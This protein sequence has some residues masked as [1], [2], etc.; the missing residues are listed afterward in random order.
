MPKKKKVGIIA[1]GASKINEVKAAVKE[2]LK[3]NK[4]LVLMQCN[5]NYTGDHSNLKFVNLNVLKQYKKLFPNTILGLSDH[6]FGHASVLGAITLG[7]RVIEKHFTDNNKRNGPDHYFAMNPKTWEEMV[8]KARE[9]EQSLGDGLKKIE[10]NE[11]NTVIVQRR[12]IRA[13]KN[14]KKGTKL[15]EHHFTY[16][17]PCPK[18]ALSPSDKKILINKKLKKNI[19]FHEVITK[20]NVQ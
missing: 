4:S 19:A 11:Q 7:A 6:T 17:R 13:R 9:L 10:K 16:L 3:I 20:K 8:K 12:G 2:Y 15:K 14:L 18:N 1:T 5:T